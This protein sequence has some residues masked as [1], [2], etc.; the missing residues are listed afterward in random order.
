MFKENIGCESTTLSFFLNSGDADA[1]LLV[2]DH[3]NNLSAD[4]Q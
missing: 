3:V 1:F 4:R 2:G